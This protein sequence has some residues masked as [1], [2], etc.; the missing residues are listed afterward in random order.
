LDFGVS[1]GVLTPKVEKTC[2]GPISNIRQNFMSVIVTIAEISVYVPE[3]LTSNLI[4]NKTH[5]RVCQ[6]INLNGVFANTEPFWCSL[7]PL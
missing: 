5:I 7:V 6:I 3:K 1:F 4:S 2:Q